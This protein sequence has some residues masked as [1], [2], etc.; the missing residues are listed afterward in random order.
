MGQVRRVANNCKETRNDGQMR[1][2][3]STGK[4]LTSCI[5]I[6]YLPSQGY[7]RMKFR[8]GMTWVLGF[9]LLGIT[10]LWAI[11]N[12]YVPIFLQA[13][14]SDFS[15]G[16]GVRGFGLGPGITGFI[17]TLDNLAGLLILPYI[18][19]LSDRTRTKW[20]RRR[21]FILGGAPIAA[22]AFAA[23]P[24]TLG[25]AL[26]LFMAAILIT[27]LAMD[28]FRT[29][30]IA[31]MPDLTPPTYRSPANGIINVMG[32][33]GGVL[34]LLGGG[35]LFRQS[36]AAPFLFGALGMLVASLVVVAVVREPAQP[37]IA[38]EA[39]GILSSLRSVLQDRD[40]SA[41][42]LLGA[43]FCWFLGYTAIEVFFTSFAVNALRLDSGQAT[44]L[45]AWFPLSI[46]IGAIPAGFLGARFGRRR[47]IL[48]GLLLFA[49]LLASV[50]TLHAVSLVR[51]ILILA[52]LA[53]SVVL[54]NSLPMV[55]DCAP[56]NRDGVYTGLYYLAFQLG[57][58]VGP[59][60]AGLV[61]ARTGNNYRILFLYA[62]L[63]VVLALALMLVVRRGERLSSESDQAT[64]SLLGARN[65]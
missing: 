37:E 44:M 56:P 22:I 23:I 49:L 5:G 38:E 1:L 6:R 25:L 55:L 26:P 2:A 51:V 14:R 59:V 10:L 4:P 61:L 50:Y 33:V 9:G 8:Y 53:W 60:M 63:T 15:A 11:Y 36:P 64:P 62:P 39:P 46:L 3:V 40:R 35:W 24:Y 34:A 43:I 41:L 52:G 28:I 7:F 32:G 42:L 54:V 31:L 65:D 48:A 18:G 29:P 30:V 20:G 16:A 21:P 57:A 19:A 13:G 45:Q 58:V 17:M 27:L 47:T 12:A